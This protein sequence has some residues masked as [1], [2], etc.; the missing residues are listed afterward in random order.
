[1]KITTE[2]ID[3]VKVVKHVTKQNVFI[4]TLTEREADLL[5]TFLGNTSSH[6]LIKTFKDGDNFNMRTKKEVEIPLSSEACDLLAGLY[7]GLSP[8]K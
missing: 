5:G 1:M 7:K 8:L 4:L 3:E 2:T 6:A